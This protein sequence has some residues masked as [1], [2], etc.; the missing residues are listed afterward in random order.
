MT[1]ASTREVTGGDVSTIHS[2]CVSTSFEKAII[3]FRIRVSS[4]SD[5]S[6]FFLVV[7][8]KTFLD[9]HFF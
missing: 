6:I 3:K 5:W 8:K 9:M 4:T 2:S 1:P 7:Q